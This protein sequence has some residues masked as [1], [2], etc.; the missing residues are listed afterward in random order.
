MS[1]VMTPEFRASYPQ[2]FKAKKNDLNGKD[3]YSVVAL[4]PKGAN[5]DALKTAAQAAIVEKWGADKSKWPQRL[6]S[7]FRDQGEKAKNVEGKQVMPAG[8][9][10][11]AIFLTLKSSQRPGVVDQSVQPIIDET[12]FYAGCWARATVRAYAYDQKG[13]Q[14][15]AFGLQNIQFVRH[16]DPLGG[17]SRA[18]DDFSAVETTGAGE[19]GTGDATSLF[20]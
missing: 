5:L 18:E 13:N 2:V 16:G 11:G 1:N 3:E 20:Q 10:A 12:Q 9:E 19:A 14:G 17:R 7:P 8:H 4:F 6:K 15:V